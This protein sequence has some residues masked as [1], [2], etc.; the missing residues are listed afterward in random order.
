MEAPPV[1]NLIRNP[2]ATLRAIVSL[3]QDQTSRR[4]ENLIDVKMKMD[5]REGRA[6]EVL[7]HAPNEGSLSDAPTEDCNSKDLFYSRTAEVCF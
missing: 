4:Y 7:I 2:R 1:N 5:L 3:S 6:V